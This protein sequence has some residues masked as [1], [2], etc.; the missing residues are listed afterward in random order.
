MKLGCSIQVLERTNALLDALARHAEPTA[1]KVLAAETGLPPSTA[2]RILAC[3]AAFG[4]VQRDGR[5]HYALGVKLLQLASR[6]HARLD[7]RREARPVMEALRDE[8]GE[9]VNLTVREG[10]EVIYIERVTSRRAVRVEQVIG[11]RAPLHVTAVGKVFLAEEDEAAVAGYV[12][13]TGL[14]PF[15]P[16]T[17]TDPVQL[18]LE[19]A[20]VRRRGY[21][22]DR[23]EAEAG[24]GCIA[25]PVRDSLGVVVAAL[26]VSA[27]VERLRPEWSGRV[28]AAGREL[29]ARLGRHPE[30]DAAAP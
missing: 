20:E 22:T 25:V 24:V 28:I 3:L 23:E 11:T 19:L 27:P 13:R 17:I 30:A 26:S 7:L 12:E 6:V 1:L 4:L 18:A 21:A 2:S 15:T 5:G 29:S 16:R 10:D 9:T 14:R 8:L